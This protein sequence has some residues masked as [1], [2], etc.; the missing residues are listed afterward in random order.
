MASDTHCPKMF[1]G[2]EHTWRVRIL[3]DTGPSEKGTRTV[4]TFCGNC[5]HIKE[6]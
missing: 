6:K 2:M 4:V 1:G 3:D 5:G